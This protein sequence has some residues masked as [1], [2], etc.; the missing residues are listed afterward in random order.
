M[1]KNLGVYSKVELLTCSFTNEYEIYKN[2]G[3]RCFG[4]IY[5]AKCSGNDSSVNLEMGIT[6]NFDEDIN[7]SKEPIIVVWLGITYSTS[8]YLNSGIKRSY[9][10]YYCKLYRTAGNQMSNCH[11]AES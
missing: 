6:R 4:S 7:S 3:R 8:K 11:Q 2:H 10:V 9:H 1:A 5:L